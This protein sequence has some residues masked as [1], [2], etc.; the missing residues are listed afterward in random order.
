MNQGHRADSSLALLEHPANVRIAVVARLQGQKARDDLQI[1]LHAVVNFFEQHLLFVEGCSQTL[2]GH[3]PFGN[4][5]RCADQSLQF[6][7]RTA[8]FGAGPMHGNQSPVLGCER[9]LAGSQQYTE[10]GRRGHRFRARAE[11]R[12]QWP[13][14]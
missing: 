13:A 8:Q 1:V 10:R 5:E 4:V 3:F 9:Q 7:L 12:R 6:A 11:Q 14:D 2:F